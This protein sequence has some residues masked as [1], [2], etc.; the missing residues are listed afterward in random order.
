MQLYT[1]FKSNPNMPHIEA[2]LS[3]Y[4][5]ND[6]LYENVKNDINY[7]DYVNENT[8]IFENYHLLK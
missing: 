5:I 8:K 3:V 1:V 7:D 2:S 4:I 6:V